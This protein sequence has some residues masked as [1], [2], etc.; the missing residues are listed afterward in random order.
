LPL[1]L[2]LVKLGDVFKGV[3][4]ILSEEFILLT[5]EETC[6]IPFPDTD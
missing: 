1:K 2:L 5:G 3:Y 6:L 4:F